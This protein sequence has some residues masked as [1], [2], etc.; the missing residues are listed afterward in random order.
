MVVLGMG[1]KGTS[2][3]AP[4]TLAYV[5]HIGFGVTYSAIQTTPVSGKAVLKSAGQCQQLHSRNVCV[6]N[7]PARSQDLSSTENTARIMK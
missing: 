1:R 3:K 6:L 2:G 4:L 5:L 7:W